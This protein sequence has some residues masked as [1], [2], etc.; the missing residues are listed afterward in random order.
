[1]LANTRFCDQAGGDPVSL[2][3]RHLCNGLIRRSIELRALYRHAAAQVSEPGLR[4]VLDEEAQSL[5]A[6]IAELQTQMRNHDRTPATRSRMIEAAR[7]RFDVWLVRG[8]PRSD[9]A[10]I[11]LLA[12]HE[13]GL[14]R[15]FERVL[16]RVSAGDMT[17]TLHRQLPRL[18]S[19]HLDMHSLAKA[20]GQ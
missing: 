5:D 12:R 9:D 11:R 10:W 14:L 7:H 18:Q 17:T 6:V 2:E 16:T 4:T 1:M 3:T 19:I 13:Q 8:M 20:V 15:A